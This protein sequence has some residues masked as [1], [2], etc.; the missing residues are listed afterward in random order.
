M[1]CLADEK[2]MQFQGATCQSIVSPSWSCLDKDVFT[3]RHVLPCYQD[4]GDSGLAEISNGSEEKDPEFPHRAWS[5]SGRGCS[6][7]IPAL[8]IFVPASPMFLEP[9]VGVVCGYIYWS[10]SSPVL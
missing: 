5:G 4:S 9:S 8:K 3:V 1:G 2:V 10:S 6:R 7:F